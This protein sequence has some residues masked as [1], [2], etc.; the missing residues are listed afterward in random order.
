M[1]LR[2]YPFL[3]PAGISISIQA[4]RYMSDVPFH[5]HMPALFST[6]TLGGQGQ[7]YTVDEEIRDSW[8]NVSRVPRIG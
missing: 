2:G 4:G 3:T 8:M 7:Q 5:T 1:N 6:V